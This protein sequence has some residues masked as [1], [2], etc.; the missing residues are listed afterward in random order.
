MT[1]DLSGLKSD[2]LSDCSDEA[3]ADSF[4]TFQK[5]YKTA[6]EYLKASKVEFGKRSINHGEVLVKSDITDKATKRKIDT[7]KFEI[8]QE[9][10]RTL[11]PTAFAADIFEAKGWVG[12]IKIVYYVKL[13]GDVLI[14]DIPP[15]VLAEMHKYFEFHIEKSVSKD[16]VLAKQVDGKLSKEELNKCLDE[17]ISFA[18][19][20]NRKS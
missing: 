4:L 14:S 7:E 12:D 3:I 6:E 8:I 19:K 10:R 5:V 11:S 15:E 1:I 20:V 18:Y 16:M 2:G 9:G 17:K 13:K